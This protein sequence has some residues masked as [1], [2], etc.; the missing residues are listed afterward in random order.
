[1]KFLNILE[2]TDVE[3]YEVTTSALPGTSDAG[4][5]VSMKKL[6]SGTTGFIKITAYFEPGS[7]LGPTSKAGILTN[8][9]TANPTAS[10]IVPTVTADVDTEL[11]WSLTKEKILPAGETSPAYGGEAEYKISVRGN[12]AIGGIP[13]E[14][15]KVI[16]VLPVGTEFVEATTGYTATPST[17]PSTLEWKINKL[18]PGELKTFNVTVRY[19][20]DYP[21]TTAINTAQIF[22]TKAGI[23]ST[24][25]AFSTHSVTTP[26][27][28]IGTISK[29]SRQP[30]DRYSVGQQVVFY[31]GGYNN[32]GNISIDEMEI[33]DEIPDGINLQSVTVGNAKNVKVF[34][35]TYIDQETFIPWT[36]PSTLPDGLGINHIKKV[37]WVMTNV[38]VGFVGAPLRISGKLLE[39]YREEL[40]P[41]A[42]VTGNSITNTVTFNAT[43]G[44]VA[45][46][47]SKAIETITVGSSDI[48]SMPWLSIMKFSDIPPNVNKRVDRK[49]EVTYTIRIKNNDYA[50]GDLNMDSGQSIIINDLPNPIMK[51]Y[52]Y[53]SLTGSAGASIGEITGSGITDGGVNITAT[54][55]EWTWTKGELKP[56]EYIDITYTTEVDKD[57]LVGPYLNTATVTTSGIFLDPRSTSLSAVAKVFVRFSGSLKS[58][59]GI[60]GHNDSKFKYPSPT[61][62][63]TE[64]LPGG[65][66][67]YQLK[68]NNGDSNGPITNVV[69]IDKFPH[70]GDTGVIVPFGRESKWSPYLVNIVTGKDGNPLT[71][72]KVY[73]STSPTPDTSKLSN[74]LGSDTGWSLTPPALITSVTAIKI[75]FGNKE[76]KPNGEPIYVE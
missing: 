49:S 39:N 33:V 31:I 43:K 9:P 37:K 58:S 12:N 35:S 8:H 48:M 28:V 40:S 19:P 67:R 2:S 52:K 68:V 70:D 41:S 71:D 69:M 53:I 60:K 1:M 16:D 29:W 66:V 36:T 64:T 23:V 4:I 20:S 46:T 55:V 22:V 17:S 14:D 26:G 59:K 72:A 47:S 25:A 65:T 7:I 63:T 18:M 75:E 30:N 34:Y 51:N 57:A 50:T 45:L 11:T 38:P 56:G 74:P 13:L 76:F 10:A 32:K 73:Y 27:P 3:S 61:A 6:N 21:S 5:I 42:V 24:K 44:S 15:V 62:I 54:A